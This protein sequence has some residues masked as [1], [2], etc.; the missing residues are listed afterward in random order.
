MNYTS[1][2]SFFNYC[3]IEHQDP[4]FL[5]FQRI[6]K[7]VAAEF[8]M[9]ENGII[10]INEVVYNKQD[11]L[12]IIDATNAVEL[13]QIHKNIDA[14]GDL[15]HF[16]EKGLVREGLNEA[17]NVLRTQESIVRYLS[18][19]FAPLFNKEMKNRLQS[20]DFESAADW[21]P[22][23]RM[24]LTTDGEQAFKSTKAFLEDGSK[25]IRN[26]NKV[27]FDVRKDEVLLWINDWARF[28]N[29][30]PDMLFA[31]KDEFCLLLINFCVEIQHVD[32]KTCHAI[33]AQ[34][35][36]LDFLDSRHTSIVRGNHEVYT[37]LLTDPRSYTSPGS[38]APPKQRKTNA[39][40]MWF[41]IGAILVLVRL[42][43]T[44]SKNNNSFQ[45]S[46][47][48]HVSQSVV[49]TF[50]QA[51]K[52]FRGNHEKIGVLK[53]INDT[54]VG[55]IN[56][57]SILNEAYSDS[58]VLMVEI[59]NQTNQSFDLIGLNGSDFYAMPLFKQTKL[60]VL[61]EDRI[62]QDFLIVPSGVDFSSIRPERISNMYFVSKK[63]IEHYGFR[64]LGNLPSTVSQ[65][66][67]ALYRLNSN[68]FEN[69]QVRHHL[70]LNLEQKDSVVLLKSKDLYLVKKVGQH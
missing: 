18:P 13:V 19:M 31:Q 7:Q 4:D 29:W 24:I 60:Y 12:N 53:N 64:Y 36:Q 17:I 40:F 65:T 68:Y 34:M 39:N 42:V 20:G 3:G 2:I 51:Q 1:I 22:N 26:L 21:I 57:F 67:T 30:L 14:Q 28:M 15:K 59:N 49:R 23:C 32:I 55:A 5:N 61:V 9:T 11:V 66:D 10:S 35:V 58:M 56:Y 27:S 41:I 8:S 37:S 44:C 38:L 6:K 69:R 16:L 25:L 62:N 46:S 54:L 33:S 43:S 70:S 45:Y 52:E 47:S 50:S 63:D 48:N